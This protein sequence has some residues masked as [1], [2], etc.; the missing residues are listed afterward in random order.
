M[1]NPGRNTTRVAQLNRSRDGAWLAF[2]TDHSDVTPVA[3]DG[4][5][6]GVVNV[7]GQW[8]RVFGPEIHHL[9]GDWHLPGDVTIRPDE[10]GGAL[11]YFTY[12]WLTSIR[13]DELARDVCPI[14]VCSRLRRIHL[15]NNGDVTPSVEITLPRPNARRVALPP[16]QQTL[17]IAHNGGGGLHT[18]MD[19]AT[20][21]VF[22]VDPPLTGTTY[23][24]TLWVP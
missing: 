2:I 16:D 4:S 22:S 5:R 20:V 19:V 11:V 12:N 24:V 15:H 18:L 17:F 7:E 6:V 23:P 13:G 10:Q 3:G 8:V 9:N 1:G 14:G 21:S